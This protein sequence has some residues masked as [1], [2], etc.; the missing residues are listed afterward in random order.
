MADAR[1]Q[2]N[3]DVHVA[4]TRNQICLPS[5][6]IHLA[7]AG[8]QEN[9]CQKWEIF[10][11]WMENMKERNLKSFETIYFS[12]LSRLHASYPLPDFKQFAEQKR[13]FWIEFARKPDEKRQYFGML[14]KCACFLCATW[15]LHPPVICG[16]QPFS[17]LHD[18]ITLKRPWIK[19]LWFGRN[20][21]SS[22]RS[23]WLYLKLL[24]GAFTDKL[25]VDFCKWN[26]FCKLL[27]N[28]M[29]AS[30]CSQ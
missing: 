1:Y 3:E 12:L 22:V 10:S 23:K 26:W 18:V 11:W 13:R 25:R 4:Q 20:D 6:C 19:M 27:V 17:R 9:K 5:D 8:G 30:G 7:G 15:K 2:Q 29:Y 28:A 24:I 16:L 14:C 21:P